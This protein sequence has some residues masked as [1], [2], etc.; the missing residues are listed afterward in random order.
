[1]PTAPRR[2]PA[3]LALLGL[4]VP[5]QVV[6]E[7]FFEF[8][9]DPN[10][11]YAL[12]LL[13]FLGLFLELSSP[14]TSVPGL[15]GAFCLV[16]A[17]IGLS[18]LPFDWRGGLLIL[19]AFLLLFADLFVPS[20]GLLT[21]GGLALMVLG[22][23]VLF[24]EAQGV[25]VSR[26]LI[27]TFTIALVAL[28]AIVGGFALSVLRRKPATGREGLVG[29]VGTVRKE[30]D[31]DGVVYVFGELWQATANGDT[32]AA[33]PPIM[34]REPV[35]VTGMDGL[36]LLVRRA[37]LT[38]VDDAGVAIVGDPRPAAAEPELTAVNTP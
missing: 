16:L 19:V 20:L 37:T 23:Y 15:F 10:I 29:A 34:E 9:A 14:G 13:G 2:F 7:P 21:L 27:W 5:L 28:F 18:Q 4:V 1:M 22:S 8:L 35:T 24:D 36:R 3:S 25:L 11:A 26:P 33:S 31:P 17:A 12:L 30:L 32:P 38:E 6:L